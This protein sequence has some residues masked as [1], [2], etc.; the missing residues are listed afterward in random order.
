MQNCP[1]DRRD[2]IPE[3]DDFKGADEVARRR[4]KPTTSKRPH[5]C[6]YRNL[7]PAPVPSTSTHSSHTM[8]SRLNRDCVFLVFDILPLSSLVILRCTCKRADRDFAQYIGNRLRITLRRFVSQE[9]DFLQEMATTNAV[10]GGSAAVAVIGRCTWSP[11]NLDVYVPQAYFSHFVAYLIHNESCHAT[12]A[13]LHGVLDDQMDALDANSIR[14]RCLSGEHIDVYAIPGPSSLQALVK[15]WSSCLLCYVSASSFCVAY[16]FLADLQ[17]AILRPIRL[18]DYQ[19]PVDSILDVMHKYQ[20]RGFDFR[21]AALAWSREVDIEYD[22]PGAGT[23]YCPLTMRYLGDRHTITATHLSLADGRPHHPPNRH[24]QQF[25]LA[26]WEG[27]QACDDACVGHGVITRP[28]T[29]V[30]STLIL[31]E[32]R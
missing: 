15:T 13:H 1:S 21:L 31:G 24:L 16:P 3:A 19:Y 11:K 32:R 8:F 5:R 22:C 26:W 29:R 28:Q 17:R 20:T 2:I 18:L 23:V 7:V 14:L 25:T 12:F 9:D 30:I 10:I 27:G 6:C 4:G